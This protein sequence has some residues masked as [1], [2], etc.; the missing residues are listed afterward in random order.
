LQKYQL[1]GQNFP[2]AKPSMAGKEKHKSETVF[3]LF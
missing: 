1:A 2:Q 3:L